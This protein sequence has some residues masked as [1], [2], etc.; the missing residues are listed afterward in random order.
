MDTTRNASM[1]DLVQILRDQQ[2]RKVD[3]VAP[4]SQFSA[5]DG[6]LVVKGAEQHIDAD[7]VTAVD[8]TY[9]PTGVFDGGLADRL[10]IP[11]AYLRRMRVDRP[12]L[13]DANVNGWLHGLNEKR[14]FAGLNSAGVAHSE[15]VREGIPGDPRS[16]LLR[17]FKGDGGT[18]VARAVLSNKYATVDHL[19]VLMAALDGIRETGTTVDVASAD[20]T[21]RRMVVKIHAP[22]IS[23][24]APTLLAGY[25]SPFTGQTGADNPVVFAGLRLTNS[26]V[27]NGRW[28]I[29]PEVT[30]LVCKNGMTMT[31]DA[32]AGTHV[33]GK[34]EEGVVRWSEDTERKN[35]DL[36]RAKT[37]D[38]VNTFLS[39]EYLNGAVARLERRAGEEVGTTD[40]AIRDL[41][42]P[43]GYT[44]EQQ[45][46]ILDYFVRGGQF[47]RAG[48]TNAITAY[49]QTVKDGDAAH[50]LDTKATSLLL[51]R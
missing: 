51:A 21:D 24:M 34:L 2:A 14:R 26:E 29:T 8:G 11:V 20:L 5:R 39:E 3:V 16:F 30:V 46:G 13:Y 7:G 41:T 9:R 31:V 22:Q 43:L 35:I 50:D 10:G 33:G 36:V 38:A 17:L 45:A 6:F 15:V 44:E 37:R 27:G 4:A 23:A 42:R 48:V 49:S 28:S 18:G 1:G 32:L 40:Q 12:D 47:T 25:R 19:D